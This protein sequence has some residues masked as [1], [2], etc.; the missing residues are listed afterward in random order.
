MLKAT[1]Q[2]TA[3]TRAM[4]MCQSA[5][6]RLADR[7]GAR[8]HPNSPRADLP[9]Q[10]AVRVET[11]RSSADPAA[12]R[13]TG[14]EQHLDRPLAAALHRGRGGPDFPDLCPALSAHIDG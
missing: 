14:I 12:V 4:A 3:S 11:I 2:T 13:H 5:I 6:G 8:D 7:H 10:G 9:L 1:A